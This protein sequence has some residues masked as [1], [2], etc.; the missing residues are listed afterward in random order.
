MQ[1]FLPGAPYF[2][3]PLPEE[4]AVYE[5]KDVTLEC[6]ISKPAPV[7]WYKDTVEI[8]VGHQD[9]IITNEGVK[10]SLVIPKAAYDHEATYSCKLN[11]MVTKTQLIIQGERS[12]AH[13]LVC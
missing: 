11:E 7:K 6:E 4:V 5:T 12:G 9:Y 8:P 3:T 2:T 1:V 13:I 10:L